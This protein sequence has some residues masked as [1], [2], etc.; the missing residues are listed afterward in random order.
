MNALPCLRLLAR[1]AFECQGINAYDESFSCNLTLQPDGQANPRLDVPQIPSLVPQIDFTI[2]ASFGRTDK[3]ED[4]TH[5]T[6]SSSE[7]TP[8]PPPIREP[9]PDEE[10]DADIQNLSIEDSP[11]GPVVRIENK[12]VSVIPDSQP[13]LDTPDHELPISVTTPLDNVATITN[14]RNKGPNLTDLHNSVTSA[15]GPNLPSRPALRRPLSKTSN[16]VNTVTTPPDAPSVDTPF[17][18]ATDIVTDKQ[19]GAITKK[20]TTAIT[21]GPS[22]IPR[23]CVAITNHFRKVPNSGTT[24]RQAPNICEW[25][26]DE[27]A[28]PSPRGPQSNAVLDLNGV[29]EALPQRNPRKRART[30]DSTGSGSLPSLNTSNIQTDNVNVRDQ[31]NRP[32]MV[33]N[34]QYTANNANPTHSTDKNVSF[35]LQGGTDEFL[36]IPAEALPFFRR[37]RG[38]YSAEARAITRSD[39]L[40]RLSDNGKPPRW[41]YGIGAMPSYV[42]PIAKELVNIKRR[43]ALELARAVSRS[44]RDSAL[45]SKRQG[46]LNLETVK[47]IYANNGAGFEQ[48]TTKLTTLVSRDNGQE[49]ERLTR[50]E[51]LIARSPTT[52]EDIINL[53]SGLKIAAKSY[54]GAVANDPPQANE[55]VPNARANNQ[56]RQRQNGRSRSRS[57]SRGR[58]AR[59]A[60][61]V[62]RRNN[63]RSPLRARE[64]RRN[65]S[66]Q[67]NDNNRVANQGRGQEAPRRQ[68]NQY[69]Q[70]DGAFDLMEQMF[71]FMQQKRR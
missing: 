68:R 4:D 24:H 43:H 34:N 52:D 37:A 62:N 44:L 69:R 26:D 47:N 9:T 71:Q 56:G 58:N 67:R 13:I 42:Q 19:T 63:S 38:C 54:A 32:S 21:P 11:A 17:S 18:S 30:G 12:E 10:L 36:P 39:H 20:A 59:N 27:S 65:P 22:D 50:R 31:T 33:T 35:S 41:A 48:A 57:R 2:M 49:E 7:D 28:P 25:S 64:N 61:N 5:P 3:M 6:A 51:E 60:D 55:N 23:G 29:P 1:G 15:N 14:T 70:R 46:N 53:V 16:N 66:R 8:N 40:D 45:A